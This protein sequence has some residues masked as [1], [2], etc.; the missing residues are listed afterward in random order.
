MPKKFKPEKSLSRGQFEKIDFVYLK[1]NFSF[2]TNSREYSFSGMSQQESA[3]LLY[4]IHQLSSERYDHI[5]ARWRKNIGIEL[6]PQCQCRD[7]Q[8]DQRFGE[9]SYRKKEETP[10]S[11]LAVF[12]LYTNDNPRLSRIIGRVINNVFYILY[13]DINGQIY[14]HG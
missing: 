9:A 4:R 12:R 3:Q 11:K 5:I 7:I 2:I 1:F 13:I 10:D 6:I 14:D 8:Y